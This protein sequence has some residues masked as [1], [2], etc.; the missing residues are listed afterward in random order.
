MSETGLR[1]RIESYLDTVMSYW[2][3]Y[4]RHTVMADTEMNFHTIIF[5]AYSSSFSIIKS[6]FLDDPKFDLT[7]NNIKDYIDKH[8]KKYKKKLRS[9]ENAG[10]DDTSEL[11]LRCIIDAYQS[12]RYEL[13]D[14]M[15]DM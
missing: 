12:L 7:P 9:R 10:M 11:S 6:A 2:V 4:E 3:A 13:F 15:L 5:I 1:Q 14:E 8:I